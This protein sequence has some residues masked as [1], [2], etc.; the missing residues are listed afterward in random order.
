M[1]VDYKIPIT[2]LKKR[3]TEII[4]ELRIQSSQEL[5]AE[6]KAL[7]MAISWLEKADSLNIDVNKK[8]VQIPQNKTN[9]PSSE[10]RIIEDHESDDKNNWE[11]I[12]IN[13]EVIRPLADSW[14]I[15]N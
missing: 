3:T 9:T 13:G 12:E 14:L 8:I 11:E 2:L 10:F 6:K 5:I 15:L 7:D 4:A 1:Q